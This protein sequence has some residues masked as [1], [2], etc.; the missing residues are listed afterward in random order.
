MKQGF[1]RQE[2][3]ILIIS[4]VTMILMLLLN[5]TIFKN[6][7]KNLLELQESHMLTTAKAVANN[8]QNYYE[9]S[10]EHFSMYFEQ[11]VTKEQL[12]EYC[13]ELP[14]VA[15]TCLMA[16]DGTILQDARVAGWTMEPES[17]TTEKT[18]GKTV[19]DKTENKALW[20][21]ILQEYK[22]HGTGNACLLPPILAAP[23][24]HYLQ[25]M[26][27]AVKTGYYGKAYVI[28]L[29][30]TDAIYQK[31]VK[32]I[33]IGENGYSM[34]KDF[35]G[36]ILMHKSADQVGLDAVEGRREQYSEYD[37]DLDDLKNWVQEQR[38][39][40]EGSRI[41]ESYW[42][43][44]GRNPV[45]TRKVVAYTQVPIGEE[46]WIVNCTLDYDEIQK[47]LLTTQRYVFLLTAGVVLIFGM[48]LLMFVGNANKNRAMA[49]EMK[50]LVEM[51]GAWEELHRREEQIRHNDKM[52]TLGAMTSMI[53]HEFNNF[54]TPIMLYGEMLLSDPDISEENK[55][56]L[57]EIVEAAEKS[58]A[59]TRELSRYGRIEKEGAKK[60]PVQVSGEIR[61]SL[62]MLSKTLP[63]NIT[64]EE[65]VEPDNGWCLQ[66]GLGMINQIIMN[67]CTNAV[68]AMQ[69]HGGTLTVKGRLLR[70][71]E[72]VRYGITVQDTGHGI[73]EKDLAQI[74][75]PFYTT[76]EI[77]VGTGLGLSVVQDLIHQ[78]SGE[79]NVISTEGQGTRFDI[80]LPLSLLSAEEDGRKK[81][82]SLEGK[83]IYVLDDNEAVG[84]AL[85]KSLKPVCSK[86]RISSRPEQALAEIRRA[87]EKW[88]IIIAD[89]SMPMMT[90]VEFAGILRSLGYSGIFIIISGCL[91]RDIRWY[92]DNGIVDGVLEKPVSVQDIEAIASS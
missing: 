70:E 73:P 19:N 69:D 15:G 4:T 33:R 34:V 40:R 13:Q 84:R 78:V 9:E 67:L 49:Q 79:I 54:L 10:L 57:R 82:G 53:S 1:T 76:K 71:G 58:R 68:H 85:E 61:R 28:A 77:G 45:K 26:V 72:S 59:L 62:K 64:L 81:T 35:D 30:D 47:P 6:Y 42:W 29:I 18:A 60:A 87:V 12:E 16:E 92:L 14:E 65:A 46:T 37:L 11:D 88:D 3:V 5:I 51:N 25:Y 27:K 8:L 23:R 80:L 90:G 86:V 91:D 41:L 31:I 36:T 48:I 74:F 56:C 75:T 32:P 44:D 2:Q 55:D 66:A 17:R 63:S 89:Y 7:Q 24:G 50:H 22:K 39:N 83:Q 38:E 52:K 21:D 43:E 20:A